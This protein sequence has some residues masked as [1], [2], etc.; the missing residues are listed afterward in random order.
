MKLL[1]ILQKKAQKY[2]NLSQIPH[3]SFKTHI[4]VLLYLKQVFFIH[5]LGNINKVTDKKKITP[6]LSH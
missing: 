5:D 4:Y 2:C 6:T 3:N 1:W